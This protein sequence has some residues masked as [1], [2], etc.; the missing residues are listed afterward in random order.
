MGASRA[1]PAAW[2]AI[3]TGGTLSRVRRAFLLASRAVFIVPLAVA[4]LAALAGG[5]LG[6]ACSVIAGYEDLQLA[7]GQT[8]SGD[9]AAPTGDAS[10]L[11]PLDLSS[12]V[13]YSVY[14]AIFSAAGNLEGVTAQLPRIHDLGFNV[15]SVMPVT[16]IGQATAQHQ[17][18]N[19]PYCVHDF[20]G[21]NAAYG[22]PLDLTALVQAA[23]QLGIYV[24][25]DEELNQTSWDNE[26][27]TEHPE[28]YVHSDKDPSNVAS[29][30]EAFTL[31]DVA[32]LDYQTI[33]ETGVQTYMTTM[34]EYWL[35][36]YDID[37]FRFL[38]ADVPQ[39][40]PMIPATF[41]Q[42]LR[43]ALEAVK[44]NILM[45][46]DEEDPALAGAPFELDYGWVLRGGQVG[47]TGGAGLQ[48]VANGADATELQQ[49]W[50]A[51][52]T[53][54]AGVRHTTL[55]QNWD[56][57]E[58]LKVYGGVA[59]TMAA[60]TF[61]FTID[62]VPML[63]NGEE[64]ANDASG[65]DTHT[66][67]DWNAPNAATFTA[68]YKSLLALRNAHTALQQGAVTWVTNNAPDQVVSYARSDSSGTLLVVINFSEA[69]VKGTVTP[70]AANGWTD[71]S[72]TGSPGGTTHVAPPN[73][74]LQP[75][76]FEVF[77]AD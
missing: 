59:N 39:G 72:P 36:T 61:N 21:L 14:P 11:P 76:D 10:A 52:V 24:I 70:P 7:S 15:L 40:S 44:P 62:G 25:L 41:W 27:I 53:G 67:I 64:V 20:Y 4:S 38:T 6:T 3:G 13:I 56:L 57:D 68:L 12:A 37:G 42:G 46:A 31:A 29:I 48:Q 26:L 22:T 51:Q 63:W 5:A 32:Q 66:L 34:L 33:P 9:A 16:P 69:A 74:S 60:A 55:L 18:F 65:P 28:Y 77:R 47:Q 17:T 23:H 73:L 1:S 8:E 75:Y 54:Y 49:A 43:P 35:T 58:D 50:Q 2:R 45:W 30:E 19:S 71:L